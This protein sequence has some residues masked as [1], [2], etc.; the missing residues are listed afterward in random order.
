MTSGFDV[1]DWFLGDRKNPNTLVNLVRFDNEVEVLIDGASYMEKLAYLLSIAGPGDYFYYAGFELNLGLM[2]DGVPGSTVRDVFSKACSN[3]VDMRV[4]LSNHFG[5]GNKATHK[6]FRKLNPPI[7]CI[8]DSRYP[9]C[10]SAH[11]KFSVLSLQGTLHAFCGG[12]DLQLDRFDDGFHSNHNRR[13]D[14]VDNFPAGWHDVHTHIQGTACIDL[15]FMFR[16][17]W[18]NPEPPR[19]DENGVY[20]PITVAVP[21]SATPPAGG[22]T[23]Q[24]LRTYACGYEEARPA[25]PATFDD[26][27]NEILV[28]TQVA[29]PFATQGE[30]SAR[31]A[32]LYAISKALD[33]IYIEDQYFF[34]YEI[35]NALLQAMIM[36]PKML[37]IVV[38][39]GEPTADHG[40]SIENFYHWETVQ[41]LKLGLANAGLLDNFA[42]YD[43]RNPQGEQIYVHAK[44]MIVDDI[45]VEI[46]SMNCNRRSTTHDLETAVAVLD[47]DLVDV[48]YG[49]RLK[50][51]TFARDLR[52]RLWNEHLGNPLSDIDDPLEGF[53]TWT[54]LADPTLNLASV[55]A[56]VHQP[57]QEQ[58]QWDRVWDKL[59]DPQGLCKGAADIPRPWPGL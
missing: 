30:F 8:L 36:H 43:L 37:V 46:G 27:G 19:A 50:A 4:M 13:K 49:T 1:E 2:L 42:I 35:A 38:V 7:Q 22:H 32:C 17:R 39:A 47:T 45:W 48:L 28:D 31:A 58:W 9:F 52:I 12:I 40:T 10:G 14:Q 34:S 5:S 18:N 20:T 24:L 54:A 33:F 56:R 16:E 11:Q 21:A 41:G 25:S 57:S 29:Y 53:K 55:Q 44:L 15:V 51:C 26:L 3:R 23:V 6:A 59:V